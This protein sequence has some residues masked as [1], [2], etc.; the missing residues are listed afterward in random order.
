MDTGESGSNTAPPPLVEEGGEE[1]EEVDFEVGWEPE[2]G[3]GDEAAQAWEV[4]EEEGKDEEIPP[5][6]LPLPP[7]QQPLEKAV[8]PSLPM[9]PRYSFRS[10]KEIAKL[11]MR[12]AAVVG[13]F[14]LQWGFR[15]KDSEEEGEVFEEEEW[16]G[17]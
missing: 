16:E 15:D 14:L 2:G 12:G 13:P 7:P 17:F 3:G 4:L 8:A 5:P 6:S 9:D 11:Y 10:A 1:E